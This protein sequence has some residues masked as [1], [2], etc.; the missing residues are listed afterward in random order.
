MT[1]TPEGQLFDL[2]YRRY[3]GPRE[4]RMRARKALVIDGI[5]TSFGIGRGVISKALPILFFLAVMAPAVILAIVV[6]SIDQLGPVPVEVPGP[7]D[8]YQVV[9]LVLFVFSAVIAPE[10]LCS[11]RRNGV[12][13]L[14]LVRPLSPA[15][16]VIARWLAF[17]VVSVGFI[18]AGQILLQAGLILGAPEPVG[19]LRDNWFDIPRFMAAGIVIALITT[20]IPLAVASFTTRR[21]YASAFVIGLFMLS[22]VVA[23]IMVE[24]PDEPD[25]GGQ[26]PST[27]QC[28]P[29]TGEYA[30]LAGLI[31]VGA[32]PIHLS[33]MI[34][35][36]DNDWQL[37][38]QVSELNSAIPVLWY[39]FLTMVPGLVL[40]RQ[41]ARLST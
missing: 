14:Y 2:G 37:A 36:N 30:G 31:S 9:S 39:I 25:H 28:E 18:Y 6:A 15:D 17:F 34:F 41:Y 11:D 35:D 4:G 29:L 13:S 26:A 40:W 27:E 3:D 10:L 23:E 19:Y 24:C 1:T 21:G 38:V 8:Y 33:D 16:Y 5:R 20:T 32:V 7:A 22:A 12:L